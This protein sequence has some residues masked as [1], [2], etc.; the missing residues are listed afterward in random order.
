MLLEARSICKRYPGVQA[1]DGVDFK[2]R[3]GQIHALVGENGA[4]KSTLMKILGGVERA[5]TGQVLLDGE[6]VTLTGP[7]DA[8]RRGIALIHQEL[9]L[10][11]DLSVAQN[12]YF[13]REPR[14]G[15]FIDDAAMAAGARDI[16]KKVGLN[17]DPTIRLGTLTV[18]GQQMVEIAKALSMDARILIMDEPTAALS[19][20]EVVQLYGIVREF[21]ADGERAVIYI[22]HRLE[23][24]QELCT[25]VTVLRD[26]VIVASHPT[27]ELTR[28][29]M[30][31]L[32]VGR[33]IDTSHRPEPYPGG[34][35]KLE[36]RHL[37]AGIVRDV[38]FTVHAGEIFGLA[39]LVGAGRTETARAIVGA[40]EK[41][42]GDVVV[43]GKALLAAS[44][45]DAVRGGIGYLSEDRKHYGLLLEQSLTQNV[46]LPSLARWSRRGVVDDSHAGQVAERSVGELAIATPSVEQK[47]K[48]LSGGN[49]QKVVIAKW[50]ARDCDV[51]IFDE[52]TRGVDVGAKDDIYSLMESLAAQGKAI[53]VISSEI[54]ELQRVAHRIG[55]M[56]Q[57]RLTGILDNAEATQEN[58]MDLATRFVAAEGE[59]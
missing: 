7:L 28:E 43:S 38:S 54:A 11:A 17:I 42:A 20:H 45:E 30:I 58:I 4:G 31:A 26:G 35:A 51:L 5:D 23:E 41:E 8:Q 50:V 14:R 15:P 19:E 25:Q 24:I 46:A 59:A 9:N 1:L 16:L 13:G 29:D 21:I 18:A 3:A 6:P 44:V 53:V 55:V 22:S 57:G 27:P 12:I 39:G 37:S 56:C 10:M 36:V 48:T 40:D 47:V 49:Q 32:M 2:L 34:E 33:V 52:P